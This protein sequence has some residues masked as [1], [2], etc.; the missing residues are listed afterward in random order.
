MLNNNERK[1]PD[2]FS[3]VKMALA[4]ILSVMMIVAM[5]PDMSPVAMFADENSAAADGATAE[6]AATE[7]AVTEGSA[8]E[9][10][11]APEAGA[12]QPVPEGG[13]GG[14]GAEAG[15]DSQE[16]APS[17]DDPE[18]PSDIAAPVDGENPAPAEAPVE[19]EE[20]DEIPAVRMLGIST[21]ALGDASVSTW[22]ELIAAINDPS[23]TRILVT[24]PLTRT[25]NLPFI[26]RTLEIDGQG[27]TLDFGSSTLSSN[28]MTLGAQTSPV[29]LTLRN[30][31]VNKRGSNPLVRAENVAASAYWTV[32]FDGV[33]C[34]SGTV[35]A[36]IDSDNGVVN[37]S[38][39]N[40]WTIAATHNIIDK[41]R[42]INF[43]G[44]ETTL[45]S[46]RRAIST[47]IADSSINVSG[48]ANVTLYARDNQALWMHSS[49]DPTPVA[50]AGSMRVNVTEASSLDISGYGS[51]TGED[52]AT[53]TLVAYSGG[54]TVSGGSKLNIRSLSATGSNNSGQPALIQQITNGEF[55][56]SGRDTEMNLISFG[57]DNRVGAT[58]RFRYGGG[59]MFNVSD[60]AVVNITKAERT[61]TSD[62][63]SAAA[64]RFG[65]AVGNEFHVTGGARVNVTNYGNARYYDASA[66][67]GDNA[68]IE[69]D[70]SDFVFDVSGAGSIIE[71]KALKGPAVDAANYANG[72]IRIGE[73]AIFIAE[74]CTASSASN[75]NSAIFKA[76]SNFEFTCNQPLYYNFVNTRA[77]GGKV[78]NILGGTFQSLNSDVAVWGNGTNGRAYDHVEGSPFRS[79]SLLSYSLGGENF[80]GSLNANLAGYGDFSSEFNTDAASFGANGMAPYT[81]VSGNNA[82]P[83]IGAIYEATNADKYLRARATVP[84]G[85]NFEGRGAWDDEVYA[86]IKV[87]PREKGAEESFVKGVSLGAE[88]FYGGESVDGLVRYTVPDGGFLRTGDQYQIVD[89]WRGDPDPSSTRI[90]RS[91]AADIDSSVREVEDVLPPTPPV[92]TDPP[93][94]LIKGCASVGGTYVATE[95]AIADNPNAP[96]N[97]ESTVEIVAALQP[98]GKGDASLIRAAGGGASEPAGDPDADAVTAQL[99]PANGAW[100]FVIPNH[101]KLNP[102]DRLYF[103]AGDATGILNP[104][105]PHIV[106]APYRDAAYPAVNY[107]TVADG[108][109]NLSKRVIGADGAATD[110]VTVSGDKNADVKFRVESQMPADMGSI[111]NVEIRDVMEAGLQLKGNAYTSTDPANVTAAISGS[112]S[113]A[114]A[115]K[116]EWNENNRTVSVLYEK[117]TAE[118]K[119]ALQGKTV[120]VEITANFA[121]DNRGV[122]QTSVKNGAAVYAMGGK[123]GEIAESDKPVA[124]LKGKISGVLFDD[125][126]EDGLNGSGDTPVA[127]VE[128]KLYKKGVDGDYADTGRAATT[129]AIGAYTFLGLDDGAYKVL[130]PEKAEKVFTERADLAVDD[131]SHAYDDG[132]SPE[133]EVN[134]ESD[135]DNLSWTANAGYADPVLLPPEITFSK[136][137]LVLKQTTYSALLSDD[138]LKA[139]MAAQDPEDGDILASPAAVGA[140]G[141]TVTF[142]GISG[143]DSH[144]IGVYKVGYT[145]T[146]SHG[147]TVARTRAVVITDGRYEI[148][149]IDD[150]DDTNDVI[151]GA[152]NFVIAS[153]SVDGKEPQALAMSFAEAYDGA[154]GKKTVTWGPDAPAGYVAYTDVESTKAGDYEI[155]WSV[156]G[157][158]KE[159]ATKKIKA[160]VVK[161][162]EVYP[163]GKNDQYAIAASNFLRNV[164]QA[165]A[166]VSDA[167]TA[168]AKLISAA[169]VTV[170][171]LIDDTDP[172]TPQ[173]D[174]LPDK[175]ARVESDG[176]STTGPFRG[177]ANTYGIRYV[178]DGLPSAHGVTI[179]GVVSNGQLPLLTVSTPDEVALCGVYDTG[180]TGRYMLG[181]LAID[182]D[183]NKNGSTES[184]YHTAIPIT[185]EVK[186]GT[187]SGPTGAKIFTEG[188]PVTTTK[189]GVYGVD[190]RVYDEDGNRADAHRVVVVNDGSYEVGNGNILKANSFVTKLDSVTPESALIPQ[191]LRVKSEAAAI[192]GSTG[193]PFDL[194]NDN[195]TDTGGY[196]RNVGEYPVTITAPDPTDTDEDHTISKSVTAKV[197]DA[198]ELDYGPKPADPTDATRYYVYGNHIKLTKS[199]ADAILNEA[200]AAAKEAAMLTALSASAVRAAPD[201]TITDAAVKVGDYGTF[202][203]SASGKYS[204][205]VKD[206]GSNASIS[207]N[208]TISQGNGPEIAATPVPLIMDATSQAG[209]LSD[210]QIFA[211]VTVSDVEDTFG[212]VME[213]D[214]LPFYGP[215]V[216]VD[217]GTP[218]ISADKKSVT[219][220]TYVYTDADSNHADVSRAIVVNDGR[221]KIE[222]GHIIEANS[223]IVSRSAAELVKN[224][225][226]EQIIEKSDAKAWA[227]DG[228]PATVRVVNASG[229]GAYEAESYILTIGIDGSTLTKQIEARVIDDRDPPDGGGQ[230]GENG[231]RY[232]IE[233]NN[234]RINVTDATAWQSETWEAYS[235]KF[236]T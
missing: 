151:I 3:K 19:S 225:P 115:P 91:D 71:L 22:D 174:P 89:A 25:T 192:N 41:V 163:G 187:L 205:K 155:T 209:I 130:A 171:K 223:F 42:T 113:G 16:S 207:L 202:T 147:A 188:T 236:L 94:I 5:A 23:V 27:N 117:L 107:V 74:G 62:A 182:P 165:A 103:L 82:A 128:V 197:V 144:E 6:G 64:I 34:A 88:A 95:S 15:Q 75:V 129:G 181:V 138:E 78:F 228:T 153:K 104:I 112:P 148:D 125:L 126:D 51:G 48:G 28:S 145:A 70:N 133:L 79:W 233:A 160:I 230:E 114:P 121:A 195:V 203:S 216:G 146:D 53:A 224:D 179:N 111:D 199:Q 81:R 21:M 214:E 134:H 13:Q 193:N 212:A 11:D 180:P 120:T 49:G 109:T 93:S 143:I 140:K 2:N 55:N 108:P 164:S 38:G 66:S 127:G 59:Q 168:N 204:V 186:Y 80:S 215:Q 68:A 106:P 39:V 43:I 30:I 24:A 235:D 86:T 90:H 98:G 234:F 142:A 123:G 73:G 47:D 222:D 185:E 50:R 162:D 196:G 227:T 87:I 8:A 218:Q 92:I 118:Q 166:M 122:Y 116:I 175:A 132:F 169:A 29:S 61:H 100:T 170:H 33:A 65:R 201:G 12:G 36:L 158:S 161:A 173:P 32:N 69:Y 52:G 131:G 136:Y 96:H 191:E 211:G 177:V 1:N 40:N 67:D 10:A 54:F 45:S 72:K 221:Y 7:G 26:T 102:G 84:E 206:A 178:I 4:V 149:V 17:P 176:D 156:D 217:G 141:T 152:R 189:A 14:E 63:R 99:D 219:K 97:I 76:G 226:N 110:S 231:D 44:G 190:Y 57:N 200:D 210:G 135:G 194:G 198:D 20:A 183:G 56:V 139:G 232:S 184:K 150:G 9:G 157:A 167:A 105:T 58:I 85:L 213:W 60:H 37:F 18:D 119:A 208:V 83:K 229:Y 220:V 101:V 159:A 31:I 77:G 154:G 172:G 137:P 46:Y 35:S 124:K